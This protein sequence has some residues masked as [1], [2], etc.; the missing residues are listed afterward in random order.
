MKFATFLRGINV[1][2]VVL[3]MED[4]KAIFSGLGFKNITTYIQQLF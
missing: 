3:K 1:G 2:G 4:V